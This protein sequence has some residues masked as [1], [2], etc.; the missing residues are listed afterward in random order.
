MTIVFGIDP[1]SVYTG[2]GVIKRHGQM[3][4]HVDSGRICAGRAGVDFSGRLS[5]IYDDLSALLQQYRPDY[6]AIERVFSG[7]CCIC[8]QVRSGARRCLIGLRTVS[9]GAGFRVLAARCKKV[10]DWIWWC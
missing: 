9:F 5:N 3:F 4:A 10:G 6:I 7:E 8:A 1:G 2:F